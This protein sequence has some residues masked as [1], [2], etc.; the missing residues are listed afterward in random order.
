M[1]KK[2]IVTVSGG[3]DPIHIGHV[4]MFQ[5]AKKLGDELVVIL[6][7]DN[8][9]KAK[10][11]FAFMPEAERKEVIE[12]IGCVD[13]VVL[14]K[15]EEHP[16]D[17]SVCAALLDLKPDIFAN[18]GDRFSDNIPEVAVCNSINCKMYFNIG[19]GGKVQSSS[20]LLDKHTEDRRLKETAFGFADKKAFIFDIDKTLTRSK[21]NM[22][23]EMSALLCRLLQKRNVAVITGGNYDQLKNQFLNQF[24]C[25][26][27]VFKNLLLLPVSG[28]Q[29]YRY[30]GNGWDQK[31]SHFLTEEQKR[32]TFE[33]F[34]KAFEEVGYVHPEK[35]YGDVIEDRESQITFSALGQ[36]APVEEKEKWKTGYDARPEIK[37]VLERYLPDLEIRL[38]GSTS[39]DITQ[40]G[41]DKAYG[42]TMASK[43]WS[44]SIGDMLYVGDAL[45]EGGNDAI[46][47]KTGIDTFQVKDEEETKRLVRFLLISL[48]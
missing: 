24:D 37:R 44:M 6:N 31:Y 17:M 45:F 22:D 23:A 28:G 8:W 3:F 32:R 5:E 11:G 33:A 12:A 4:R 43:E 15:H 47:K 18:G 25:D 26:E 36:K 35:T 1:S 21:S 29:M 7:N 19:D 30:S 41:I 20:W 46:V 13:A 16:T 48:K 40:K 34:E 9:L 38:G 2:I 42:V 27:S 39:I 14:T 10:K